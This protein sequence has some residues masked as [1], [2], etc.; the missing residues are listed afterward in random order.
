MHVDFDAGNESDTK[1]WQKKAEEQCNF[2]YSTGIPQVWNTLKK[3]RSFS[4][5]FY[6]PISNKPSVISEHILTL[7]TVIDSYLQLF[8]VIELCLI[9][10]FKKT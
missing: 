10:K 5:R 8:T 4:F 7:A 1:F 2:T 9:S 3:L 6:S